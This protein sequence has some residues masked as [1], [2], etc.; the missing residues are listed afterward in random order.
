MIKS[1]TTTLW[2]IAYVSGWNW[3]LEMLVFEERER[4]NRTTQEEI[5]WDK[6]TEVPTANS[7]HKWRF[8]RL[9][10]ERNLQKLSKALRS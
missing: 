8:T 9:K 1:S 2:S 5:S 7:T 4:E 10:A 3:D 6:G